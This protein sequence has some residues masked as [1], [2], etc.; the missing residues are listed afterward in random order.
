M[1]H[2]VPEVSLSPFLC[3]SCAP[4]LILLLSLPHHIVEQWAGFPGRRKRAGQVS[5]P[6]RLVLR[7]TGAADILM[8]TALSYGEER[9]SASRPLGEGRAQT[10]GLE[11]ALIWP[12]AAS[13]R[14]HYSGE[15]AVSLPSPLYPIVW[16]D[17]Y[18]LPA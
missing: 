7:R 17:N 18:E 2:L 13:E 1:V 5:T 12:T 11:E 6:Q 14:D 10:R 4:L 9:C 8:G 16:S 15:K 3:D